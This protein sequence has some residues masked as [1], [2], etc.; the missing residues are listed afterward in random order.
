[1]QKDYKKAMQKIS[2]SDNDKARILANV[3]NAYEEKEE[4]PEHVVP[5]TRRPRFSARRIG[6][7]AAA[8]VVICASAALIHNQ[9]V[10]RNAGGGTDIPDQPTVKSQ[11]EEVVWEELDSIDDIRKK[12]DCKTY[13]LGSVGKKY[14]VK[15]V[16]VAREQKHVKITYKSKKQSDK[17]L[18]EYKEEENSSDITRQFN[19]ETELSTEKVGDS[20]VKMYGDEKC[21]GMTWQKESYTFAVKMSKAWS[22]ESA[23]KIV[24]ETREKKPEEEKKKPEEE[25]D[26]D[27]VSVNPNAVG[28]KGDERESTNKEKK[29]VLRDIYNRLG[30]RVTVEKPAEKVVYK[31]VGDFESF[32]FFYNVNQE[33]E[34]HRIIGYAGW[35][36]CPD[37]VLNGYEEVEEI[38]VNGISAIVYQK[39][40]A[41]KLFFFT[42]QDISFTLLIDDWW[43]EN[44]SDVMAEL[45]TVIRISMDSGDSEEEDEDEPEEE[46]EE[47]ENTANAAAYREIAQKIQDAVA[48]ESLKKLS[49]YVEFPLSVKGADITV[50]GSR[51]FLELDSEMIFTPDWVDAVVSFNTDK[52]KADTR[53]FT[54]GDSTNSLVCK[55]KNNSVVITELHVAREAAVPTATPQ[56]PLEE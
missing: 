31:K 51:E 48:E 46:E 40:N 27:K 56:E 44:T 34:N 47:E 13:M 3:I 39:E 10:G 38:S 22:K 55:I 15:K 8:F 26:D 41:G 43:G 7:A 17:I 28:W 32:A 14:K 9:F 4:T 20:D 19:G 12:T 11:P 54:M 29:N 18:F 1:M 49:S 45:M 35:D 36:G 53:S 5:I 30:F 33:L 25:K 24:S 42:K 52:I 37:G 16:E 2:L 21:D 50:N 6:A 23:R